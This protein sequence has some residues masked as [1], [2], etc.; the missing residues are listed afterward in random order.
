[1]TQHAMRNT[2]YETRNTHRTKWAALVAML[3]VAA[4][5]RLIALDAVPPGLHHDEVIIAQV[6]KDILHGRLA[7]YFPEG[8]GHEPLY[9]Y[10]L[11][12]MFAAG[13][14][15]EFTLRLTTALLGLLTVAA[16]YRM[17]CVMLGPRVALVSAAWMAV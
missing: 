2:K 13:G 8:Y 7:I 17:A 15:N 1:M 5:F 14:A 9:H 3:L 6:A 10:I 16:A 4:A 12:G 11:A